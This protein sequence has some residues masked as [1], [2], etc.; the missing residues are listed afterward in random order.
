MAS[1]KGDH[2]PITF[3]KSCPFS[4]SMNKL[5][6]RGDIMDT[7]GLPVIHNVGKI[8]EEQKDFVTTFDIHMLA[9]KWRREGERMVSEVDSE[10]LS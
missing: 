2:H 8:K 9:H 10:R 5:G 3:L 7:N 6:V 4:H 1:L